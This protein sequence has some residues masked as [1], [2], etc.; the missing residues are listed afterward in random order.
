MNFLETWMAAPAAGAAGWALLHSLWE[1]AIAAAA[2]AVVLAATRSPRVRYWAACGALLALLAGFGLTLVRML[3]ESEQHLRNIA[4][5]GYPAWRVPIGPDAS[6]ASNPVLAAMAPWL[7]SFWVA[8]VWI[9]YLRQVAG[10]LSACR[11]RRRGVCCAPARWQEQLTRWSARCRVSRPV[12]LLESCLADVPMVLGHFRPIVLVPIGL[13][14][15]L[16]PGQVEAI[17]MH[18]LAHIRRCDYLVNVLQRLVE[19]LFFYHPAAWW[20]SRVI[21]AEREA[22]C[23]DMVVQ[24]TGQAHEYASALAALEQSRGAVREP[25]LAATGGSLV[26]RIHRLLYPSRPVSGWTPLAAAVILIA[27]AAV[28]L[29]A[30]QAEPAGQNAATAASPTSSYT[31]WLNEDVVYIISDPERAAFQKLTTDDERDKFIEQFWLR[32][33]P[34]PGTA[35]NAFKTEHYRRIG[36]ANRHFGT[37]SGR[38]GW[39]TDRGHIYIVYGP[40]DEIEL[41]EQ[42]AGHGHSFQMWMYRSVKDIGDNLTILFVDR[43]GK[44]DYNLA[45]GNARFYG[46]RP[47]TR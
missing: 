43:S 36:Y 9:F 22:C 17:L 7:A 3:P 42:D 2:L 45:P 38:P 15:A 23:D 5:P 13:L 6:D 4:P 25:A 37:A 33:D 26:K 40:P 29:A 21:R 14:T 11:L 18:E 20:I 31:K 32:R 8:G 39:Q 16:P 24:L 1:G 44:G 19:G 27:S 34:K 46:F 41:H 30:W 35:E 10:W 47:V 28:A 12:V